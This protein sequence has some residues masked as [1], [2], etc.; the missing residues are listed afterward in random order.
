MIERETTVLV[1]GVSFE[2]SP[3][4]VGVGIESHAT[5]LVAIDLIGLPFLEV[6][7]LPP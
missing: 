4:E 3:H 2:G 1:I 7:E 6:R 5:F